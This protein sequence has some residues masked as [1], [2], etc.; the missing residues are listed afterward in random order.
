[1]SASIETFYSST[2][3]IHY[4]GCL[5]L[6]LESLQKIGWF[7]HDSMLLPIYVYIPRLALEVT[8]YGS[9][10]NTDSISQLTVQR[11]NIL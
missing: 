6:D 1:V 10:Y 8:A 5:L 7:A 4:Y 9:V 11:T 3:P 2:Q